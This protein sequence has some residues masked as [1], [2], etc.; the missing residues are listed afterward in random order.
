MESLNNITEFL[1]GKTA[2]DFL[3]DK[4]LYFAIVKNLEIIGEAS[5]MLSLEFKENH[6]MTSWKDM[7]GM[8]HILVHGYYQ[9][10]SRII[11]ATI[12][13]DLP[14]LRKQIEDYL[15]EPEH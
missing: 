9:V 8:R 12:V 3:L 10:D 13:N 1:E 15:K 5:Y 4:L 6:P 11:W 2:E 7:I 14:T